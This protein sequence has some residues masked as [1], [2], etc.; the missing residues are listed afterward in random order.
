MQ[1]LKNGPKNYPAL[2]RGAIYHTAWRSEAGAASLL[3]LRPPAAQ[4]RF[5]PIP[6]LPTA[7]RHHWHQPVTSNGW[8]VEATI[9]GPAAE[10]SRSFRSAEPTAAYAAKGGSDTAATADSTPAA[11]PAGATAAAATTATASPAGAGAGA[12]VAAA[13]ASAAATTATASPAGAG[14][15]AGAGAAVAAAAASAAVAAAT[16]SPAG[17]AAGAGAGAGA[18]AGAAAAAAASP[19]AAAASFG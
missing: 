15:G 18:A 10:L 1:V 12:A 9:S 6:V 11:S 8:T 13:A 16:A 2:N 17:A 4:Q 7:N 14:A 3:G 5:W 19:I